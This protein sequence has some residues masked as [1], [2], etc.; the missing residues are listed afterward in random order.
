MTSGQINVRLDHR[1]I[2]HSKV[3]PG[4]LAG[5]DTRHHLE[6]PWLTLVPLGTGASSSTW[7]CVPEAQEL[8]HT[9]VRRCSSTR[10]AGRAAGCSSQRPDSFDRMPL[11]RCCLGPS[12]GKAESSKQGSKPPFPIRHAGRIKRDTYRLT[13]PLV[14]GF[15]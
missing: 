10:P 4:S 14:C 6:E 11:L 3:Q 13:L 9:W 7:T 5:Q 12:H 1:A 2:S 15:G 8:P